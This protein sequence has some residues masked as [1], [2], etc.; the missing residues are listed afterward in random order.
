MLIQKSRSSSAIPPALL[1]ALACQT[2][3]GSWFIVRTGFIVHGV[4]YFSLFDD[5][6]VSMRYAQ[7]FANGAGLLWNPGDP[8]VEGYTNLLWTL[9]MAVLHWLAPE[10]LVSLAV[11]LSGLGLL[12]A[13]V[14]VVWHIGR[15]LEPET[16]RVAALAACGVALCYPL[17]Y[18]TL[19][20][21]E[22]GLVALCMDVAVLITIAQRP[23][24]GVR[25]AA[26]IGCLCALPLIRADGI[27]P[28]ILIAVYGCAFGGQTWTRRDRTIALAV[29]LV[30]FGGQALIRWSYY[31]AWLPNTYF[32]K[33]SGVALGERLHRGWA[34]FRDVVAG[35]LW[36][37]ALFAAFGRPLSRK[38]D[39]L[40]WLCVASCAYSVYVGGDAWEFM[41]YANRYITSAL[42][43]AILLAACGID[44]I[45]YAA[46]EQRRW[47][48]WAL[49]A[50]GA[51]LIVYSVIVRPLP[52]Q[53]TAAL[54]GVC[55]IALTAWLIARRNLTMGRTVWV[56]RALAILAGA[57]VLSRL[58][59][60]MV[61]WA[62]FNAAYVRTDA[63]M[64]TI[65]VE[66]RRVT[67]SGA[68]IAVVWA[69]A[70]PY[71][72]RLHAVDFLG[73]NDVHIAHLPS[74]TP[75]FPGHSKWDTPYSISAFQPDLV[76]QLWTPT[77]A[78]RRFLLEHGYESVAGNVYVRA[79]STRVVGESVRQ[80]LRTSSVALSQQG[81]GGGLPGTIT[82]G[83]AG[84]EAIFATH[85]K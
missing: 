80:A 58:S 4:R 10:A 54:L 3:F 39:L 7:N 6:M 47:A 44:R 53:A 25:Q 64:A 27:L 2:A 42:P 40:A 30:A 70:V 65:G 23:R 21:M 18:W 60:G 69:G 48:W 63:L 41:N 72:S 84:R 29:P 1:I 83:R 67:D 5:A 59:A 19:R 31:G 22:V 46:G 52:M 15:E 71:F 12:I 24:N 33:M 79:D 76:L 13:N 26:L 37:T 78:D 85:P 82:G 20:G 16:T 51:M 57:L 55:F 36:S 17:N 75:F 77:A 32:L 49:G 11:M 34:S 9:W 35:N 62:R 74:R 8:P 43:V 61:S 45:A 28:A 68:S 14:V 56:E 50:G 38:R 66:L 81:W 73:K